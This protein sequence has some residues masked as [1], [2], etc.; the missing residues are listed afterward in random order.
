MTARVAF[1][2]A[3]EDV[4]GG[5]I[6]IPRSEYQSSGELPVVDQ[7][8]SEIAGFTDKLS[9]ALKI[10]E[11]VIV[12]GDHTRAVKFVDFRFALGADGVKVLRAREGFEPKF[13]YHYLRT[14]RLPN[15][16]YSRHFKFLKSINLPK[17]T[18]EEQQ[19]VVEVLD[20]ADEVCK[21]RRV[22]LE[23]LSQLPQSIFGEM[24]GDLSTETRPYPTVPLQDWIDPD[25]PVTYGILM[26][27]PVVE[28]G[29]PYVR[30]A[31]MTNGGVNLATVRRTT[32]KIAQSYRRSQLKSGDLLISIRGHVGRC[33]FVPA[34][35]AG[36]NITQD[37][38]RLALAEPTSA[39]YV[40][41]AL[42]APALQRW[43]EQRTKGAAVR[44]IN[45]GDLRQVPIPQPPIAQQ[46]AFA[47]AAEAIAS[48]VSQ[49]RES[50]VAAEEL[51]A[52]LQSR[53][54]S[55]QL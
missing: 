12:F 48:V 49:A 7:G 25:R 8:R 53:A 14:V 36:G 11:P 51:L 44:G 35:L 24:F 5:N 3:L 40:R 34:E 13:V 17:P 52:S 9:S 33:A 46:A 19:R 50:L 18:L 29:V 42:E 1:S 32:T 26:P 31:D 22:F 20:R 6:K 37:S 47:S 2:E 43:M 21:K 15:A 38:A 16:G 23:Q 54:F 45:L 30:V 55:G 28:G 41:A 27:G 39:H 4:T 10:D